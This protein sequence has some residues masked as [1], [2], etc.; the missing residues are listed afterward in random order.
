[1]QTQTKKKASKK[2]SDL[3]FPDKRK[4]VL[5]ARVKQANLDYVSDQAEKKEVSLSEYMDTLIEKQRTA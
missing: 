4:A 2:K 5:F 3:Q 1:M